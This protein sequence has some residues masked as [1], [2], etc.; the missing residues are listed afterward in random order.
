MSNIE[1]TAI[2]A[3]SYGL[4]RVKVQSRPLYTEGGDPLT[5]LWL[6]LADVRDF[7]NE[8]SGWHEGERV[9]LE[10]NWHRDSMYVEARTR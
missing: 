1:R 4:N 2:E 7:V 3:Q 6:T 10:T 9:Y 5:P 8:T